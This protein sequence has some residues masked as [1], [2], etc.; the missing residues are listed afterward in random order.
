MLLRLASGS[1]SSCARGLQALVFLLLTPVAVALTLLWVGVPLL[2]LVTDAAHRLASDERSSVRRRLHLSTADDGSGGTGDVADAA[3]PQAQGGPPHVRLRA[4]ISDASVRRELLW[5]GYQGSAGLVL[6]ALAVVEAGLHL[7]LW[8]LPGPFLAALADRWTIALL[9]APGGDDLTGRVRELTAWRSRSVD[10]HAAELRRIERDLH[11]GAQAGLV[12]LALDLGMA[13]AA[14]D[15]DPESARQMIQDARGASGQVLSQLR[16]LVRGIYPPVLSERGL[17]DAVRSLAL[18]AALPVDVKVD[19]P[20][21]RLPVAL[22]TAAYF[23][24]SETVTNAVKH[25]QA[26]QVSVSIAARAGVLRLRVSDDG[27]GGA[28]PAGGSG[29]TGLSRRLAAFDGSLRLTS[30]AGGPTSVLVEV[31]CESS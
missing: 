2:L 29:L 8:W 12:A 14:L 15:E 3:P 25:A 28:D 9:R 22:E 13:Q 7:A 17:A 21:R 5:L 16:D 6:A 26:T 23:V 20:G 27:I 19:L 10:S 24:V 11:D 31:P 1:A 18:A 30:P 4:R